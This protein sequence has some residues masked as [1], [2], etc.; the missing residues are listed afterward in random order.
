MIKIWAPRYHDRKVL[1]ARYKLPCGTGV[2]LEIQKGACKGFY[3]ASSELIAKSP[4]ESMRTKSGGT[5]QVRA[6]PLDELERK[7]ND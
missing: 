4:I 2:D 1:V 7:K 3:H 6:I 5:I